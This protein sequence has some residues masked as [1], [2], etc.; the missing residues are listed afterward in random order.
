MFIS[1]LSRR[2]LITLG[3]FSSVA[4]LVPRLLM[5]QSPVITIT[6]SDKTAIGFSPFSGSDGAAVSDAVKRDLAASNAFTIGAAGSGNYTVRGTSNG[7]ALRGQLSDPSGKV[8]LDKTYNGSLKQRAHE[9][10]DDI[11][12]AV[13][14]STGFAGS[15]IAFVA[16]RTGR[17][18]IYTADADGSNVVQ[19]TKDGTISVAPSLSAD[20]R[21][22]L[23]T[24]YQ[25]GYADVYSIDLG[26]GSRSRLLKFPG[27]NSGAV[28]S[29][30]G[31]RIAVTLSKDG[32]PELYVVGAAG[33]SPQRL[34]NTSGVE[35]SPTWSPNGSE[36]IY[37]S[38]SS[39]SP[40]LYKISASGGTPQALRTGQPYNT[41]PNW[42]P[43]GSKVAFNVRQGGSFAVAIMNLGGGGVRVVGEGQDPVWGPDSR[44]LLFAQRDS[45]IRLDTLSGTRVQVV[46]GVGKISEPAWS[47]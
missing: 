38:D 6:K 21:K 22:L 12:K 40:Q 14:G 5:A 39:G 3:A 19:L 4:S 37:S 26:S 36:I 42:S 31:S 43:D 20:R 7:S 25:S 28:Y 1:P 34:T 47:H 16:T 15:K 23:Y 11:V 30:D 27:T 2:R 8:L 41:E 29:P 45:L 24:G 33:G 35:S 44:H 17:K 10:A 9:F 32:N 18:E 46:G 13:T